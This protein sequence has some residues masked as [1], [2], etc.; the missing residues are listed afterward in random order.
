MHPRNRK[1]TS[2]RQKQSREILRRPLAVIVLGIARNQAYAANS[3]PSGHWHPPGA[4]RPEGTSLLIIRQWLGL[5][6]CGGK[7]DCP[8]TTG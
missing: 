7:D 4:N 6:G 3:T 2:R 1:T 8:P 5:P